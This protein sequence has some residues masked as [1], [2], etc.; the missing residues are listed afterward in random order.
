MT[1]PSLRGETARV[2][3]TLSIGAFFSSLLVFF[4]RRQAYGFC[5]REKG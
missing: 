3:S 1:K 4:S 2:S 5:R